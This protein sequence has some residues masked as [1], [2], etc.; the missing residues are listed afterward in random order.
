MKVR[1]LQLN[2]YAITGVEVASEDLVQDTLRMC[3]WETIL[4][5]AQNR[6]VRLSVTTIEAGDIEDSDEVYNPETDDW[7]WESFRWHQDYSQ[8]VRELERLIEYCI[9]P[10]FDAMIENYYKQQEND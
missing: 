10:E 9:I 3:T 7:E 2:G 4:F 5:Y 8:E 6:L 1:V